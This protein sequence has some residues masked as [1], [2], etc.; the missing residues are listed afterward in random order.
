V[1]HP[2]RPVSPTIPPTFWRSAAVVASVV[3]AVELVLLVVTGSALLLRNG[4][5][6]A[7]PAK[8]KPAPA[9]RMHAKPA[10][11]RARV[12]AAPGLAR[13]KV[14]VVILNGNGRQGAAAAAATRVRRHGYRIRLVGNAGRM[15]YGHSLVMYRP[16]YEG[17]GRRLARDL[18]IP[19]V[20]LLDGMRTRQLHGAQAVV[21]VGP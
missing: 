17:E 2:L 15:T 11:H 12:V 7:A 13:S 9:V 19:A 3:A 20:G 5:S 21:I 1:D 6:T 18:G 16:G 14:S 4:S 8:T 10:T